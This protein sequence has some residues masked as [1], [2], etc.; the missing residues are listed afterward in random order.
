MVKKSYFALRKLRL[1]TS[2]LAVASCLALSGLPLAADAAGLG[3]VSVF[4]ALGQPLR[5]EIELSATREELS[6]MRAQLASADAF[7]QAGLDLPTT[8][9]GIKFAIDKRPN[10]VSVIKLTS[11]RPIND[12]FVDMLLEINWPAGRLVREYTFLLDPPEVAAKAAAPVAPALT[13]PVEARPAAS[14]EPRPAPRAE[15]APPRAAEPA[16]RAAGAGEHE[17]KRGETLRKIANETKPEGVSLEQ[18]LVG[19][20][21]ANQEAFDGGNMNRLKAGKILTVPEKGAVEAVS[22]AEAKKIVVAQS[23][24]WNA[25][26]R[27]LAG[28]AAQAPVSAD[29]GKQQAAGRITAKV[30]DK[31]APAEAPKDQ[32]RVSTSGAVGAK[33]AAVAKPSEEDTVAREKAL[34]EANERLASLEKNVA[35]LQKLVDMKNQS[36]AELQ[37]QAAGKAPPK[38]PEA[39][40]AAPAL[41]PPPP[42]PEVAK[43]A[44]PALAP[45]AAPEKAEEPAASKADEIKPEAAPEPAPAPAEMPKPKPKVVIPPPEPEPEPSFVEELLGNPS[46]LG[47]VGGI[48]ALLAGYVVYK[49]RRTPAGEAPI[50]GASTLSQ[51]SS[52]TAN[53]V[54]RSTGGQSV[55]TSH[56]PAQTDFSQ[57]GPGSIDTDEVDPVAEADVYMAYGRDAQAEEILLEAKQKDPKRFAIH[58][59]LLEIYANRKSLKQFEE[60]ATELYSETGGAGGDW[61]KAAA[62]G[63]KLDPQNPLYGISGQAAAASAESFDPDATLVVPAQSA[64]SSLSDSLA[65]LAATAVAGA[66]LGESL[67]EAAE[68][69]PAAETAHSNELESLDFDLGVDSADFADSA[70]STDLA[71]E[72]TSDS[73]PGV[74]TPPASAVGASEAAES[75]LPPEA[76]MGSEVLDFDLGAPELPAGPSAPESVE[77]V[78]GAFG[79][80][81]AA[82][83]FSLP[84]ISIDALPAAEAPAESEVLDFDLGS[85][86]EPFIAEAPSA[87][88]AP[89]PLADATA[90]AGLEDD[91]LDFDVKL[92][93]STILGQPMQAPSFDISALSLDLAETPPA[94]PFAPATAESDLEH[95]DTVVNTGFAAEQ[96]DTLVNP[97]FSVEQAETVVNPQ[98]GMTPEVAPDF[99]IAASEEVATKLDLAKAYEEMGDLEGARELL[100]EVLGEG[101]A[102]QREKAQAIL[103]KIGE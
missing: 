90:F 76:D 59:K 78:E 85:E 48:L 45:P 51:Q 5:A 44:E 34:R 64:K 67:R 53:S 73:A 35:E 39:V 25:Y 102:T 40:A 62:M 54:F 42:A 98:F 80:E 72:L 6:G 37:K 58:L 8:L 87:A 91:A 31:A 13:R 65:P 14:A 7:R 79:E 86:A 82:L 17:V 26:R 46:L 99:Q 101:D 77:S 22:E 83:D 4:S 29:A 47:G 66:A 27:K 19:L 69:E 95:A 61:E 1:R 49:R 24:D 2:T 20:F 43:S 71:P 3:K 75:A 84:E 88:P 36:L 92:T 96:V 81:V 16:T 38:A 93:D 18:M 15:R 60:L 33:G 41:V 97:D 57:A 12:P 63:L 21:R 89:E 56:T 11:D 68:R 23:S 28:V 9:L 52:L 30:E 32:V 50:V 70:D 94:D 100:Q 103:A 55:D 10:G 74:A